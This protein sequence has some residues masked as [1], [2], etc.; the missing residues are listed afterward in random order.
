M[1]Y[2]RE[3]AGVCSAY[4]QVSLSEGLIQDI[5]VVG[6]CDGNLQAIC[7]LL[8][9]RS[10]A[11]AIQ[12]LRGITCDEKATSCPNEISKCIEEAMAAT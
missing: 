3:N 11:E 4:T 9:G 5:E 1:T 2:K 8:K 7:A 6:G 12:L 10:A